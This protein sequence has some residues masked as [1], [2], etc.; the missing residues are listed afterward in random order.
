MADNYLEKRY[1]E[2]FGRGGRSSSVS[3]HPSLDTLA[4]RVNEMTA[5]IDAY[6]VNRVQADLVI[7]AGQ[8]VA[9]S[10]EIRFIADYNEIEVSGPSAFILGAVSEMMRLKAA[11]L[12][13]A[14]RLTGISG[15]SFRLL[16][17]K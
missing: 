1:D 11:D 14:S 8:S 15:S 17:G 9:D 4:R 7:A 2:V 12:G 10:V 16:L 3:V 13:L 5:D 6:P